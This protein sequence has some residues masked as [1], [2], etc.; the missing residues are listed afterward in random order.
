MSLATS[1]WAWPSAAGDRAHA[2]ALLDEL[3]TLSTRRYVPPHNIAMVHNGLGDD[4]EALGWLER[5]R[6]IPATA[7]PVVSYI[8]GV[9]PSPGFSSCFP[10][11]KYRQSCWV[12]SEYGVLS[13]SKN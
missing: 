5:A 11:Y 2:L 13:N 6:L 3:K 8:A 4:D 10:E 9:A 12:L 7:S 1:A